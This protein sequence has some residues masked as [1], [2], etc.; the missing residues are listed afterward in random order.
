MTKTPLTD[1]EKTMLLF[2]SGVCFG[3]HRYPI[4]HGL[5]SQP[6]SRHIHL[7]F[8]EILTRGITPTTDTRTDDRT[9]QSLIQKK[10][11]IGSGSTKDRRIK[12]STQG[13]YVAFSLNSE[14]PSQLRKLY[15]HALKQIDKGLVTMADGTKAAVY[16]RA[17]GFPDGWTALSM[18]NMIEVGYSIDCEDPLEAFYSVAITTTPTAW[19]NDS[20]LPAF[21]ESMKESF[22]AGVEDG[23][24]L[25]LAPLG[26][27][28]R[29]ESQSLKQARISSFKTKKAE[30]DFRQAKGIFSLDSF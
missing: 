25:A 14:P 4:A 21:D 24:R 20:D 6:A 27:E 7:H 16:P 15:G 19:P 23:E 12:L 29:N 18:L 3:C 30:S 11:L 10:I 2:I 26:S 22:L 5:P 13:V 1:H 9:L 17:A 28:W 8:K